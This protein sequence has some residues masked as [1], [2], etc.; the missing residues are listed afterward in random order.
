[1]E[2]HARDLLEKHKHALLKCAQQHPT[3]GRFVEIHR[4]KEPAIPG[5]STAKLV[6]VF[7]A[8]VQRLVDSVKFARMPGVIITA[9]STGVTVTIQP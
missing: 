2:H 4:V 1:M 7:E 5:K 6:G 8:D 9:A 3:P